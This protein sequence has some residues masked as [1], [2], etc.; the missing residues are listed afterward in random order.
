MEKPLET[1]RMILKFGWGMASGSHQSGINC[2][3]QIYGV[4]DMVPACELYGERAHQKNNG[5]CQHFNVGES[6]PASSHPNARQL[7]SSPYIPG[8]FRTVVPA[9]EL[10]KN[11]SE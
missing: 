5:L 4:S 6:C 11:E 3:S 2:V 1:A 8:A 10:R 9:L 7:I